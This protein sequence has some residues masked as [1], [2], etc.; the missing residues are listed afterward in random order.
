M[1][2]AHCRCLGTTPETGMVETCK[3]G[4]TDGYGPIS[5][6]AHLQSNYTPVGVYLSI[7]KSP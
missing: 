2:I 1:H 7:M 5:G 4:P 6:S 3:T